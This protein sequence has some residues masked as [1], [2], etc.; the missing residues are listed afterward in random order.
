[1]NL[2]IFL[3]LLIAGGFVFLLQRVVVRALA[4]K[5]N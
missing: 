3:A 4:R 1:M 2:T 5:G